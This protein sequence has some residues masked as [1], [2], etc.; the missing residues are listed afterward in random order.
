MASLT[1]KIVIPIYRSKIITKLYISILRDKRKFFSPPFSKTHN[2][3]IETTIT[4]RMDINVRLW[5]VSIK[6]LIDTEETIDSITYLL[7]TAANNPP[8]HKPKRGST[9]MGLMKNTNSEIKNP[10]KTPVNIL[11]KI[12]QT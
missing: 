3:K 8:T 5:M 11:K 10:T 9:L 1:K 7:P 6:E 2:D 12:V 4:N